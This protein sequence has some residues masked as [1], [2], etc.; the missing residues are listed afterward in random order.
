[1]KSTEL[2]SPLPHLFLSFPVASLWWAPLT[3]SKVGWLRLCLPMSFPTG[4]MNNRISNRR[5]RQTARLEA[6]SHRE[7][8]PPG[9]A[10]LWHLQKLGLKSGRKICARRAGLG[11]GAGMREICSFH[12]FLPRSLP[13][14]VANTSSETGP[15]QLHCVLTSDNLTPCFVWWGGVYCLSLLNNVSTPVTPQ[16]FSVFSFW[17]LNL[18]CPLFSKIY[19]FIHPWF[20]IVSLYEHYVNAS[21][22]LFQVEEGFISALKPHTQK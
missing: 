13:L 12:F 11:G 15:F 22:C 9:T 16:Y 10:V 1:M 21:L 4:L 2:T 14:Y 18:K 5:K 7:P 19:V 3:G 17:N 20:F 6:D 8:H